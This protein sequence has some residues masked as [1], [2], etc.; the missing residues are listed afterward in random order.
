MSLIPFF[1]KLESRILDPEHAGNQEYLMANVTNDK[2]AK[3][4]E[5]RREIVPCAIQKCG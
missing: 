4:E 3:P 5:K 2:R 1:L